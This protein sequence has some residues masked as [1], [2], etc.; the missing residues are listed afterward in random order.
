[1]DGGEQVLER[2]SDAAIEFHKSD[3][4]LQCSNDEAGLSRF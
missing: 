4:L 3:S 2:V 1:M